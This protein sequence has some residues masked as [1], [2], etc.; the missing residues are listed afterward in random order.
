[1]TGNEVRLRMEVTTRPAEEVFTRQ[2]DACNRRIEL[3][4][5]ATRLLQRIDSRLRRVRQ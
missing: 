2:L 4:R 5:A 3:H 1:M